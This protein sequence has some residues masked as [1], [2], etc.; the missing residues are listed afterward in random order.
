MSHLLHFRGSYHEE[1]DDMIEIILAL[2]LRQP[3]TPHCVPMA[4]LSDE[5][6]CTVTDP[7]TSCQ[8]KLTEDGE[9]YC[10]TAKFGPTTRKSNETI[11]QWCDRQALLAAAV[12]AIP[13]FGT[14]CG[15]TE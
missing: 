9:Y 7:D 12:D 6:S 5:Y 3:P 1:H 13:D 14:A 11:L 2:V 15:G 8:T 4:G 10:D